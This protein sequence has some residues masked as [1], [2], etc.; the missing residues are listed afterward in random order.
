MYNFASLSYYAFFVQSLDFLPIQGKIS[1]TFLARFLHAREFT[2]KIN[3]TTSK[4]INSGIIY[5]LRKVLEFGLF[6]QYLSQKLTEKLYLKV[7]LYII[8]TYFMLFP[9]DN[10][11]M[12]SLNL[13][14]SKSTDYQ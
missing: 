1:I 3:E 5:S 14:Q 2:Y 9:R 6:S 13:N 8:L 10:F 12:C 7:V 4:N 11:N